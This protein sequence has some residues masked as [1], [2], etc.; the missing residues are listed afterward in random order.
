MLVAATGQ[1]LFVVAAT[2][3]CAVRLDSVGHA[4][5]LHYF[6][7]TGM[8]GIARIALLSYTEHERLFMSFVSSCHLRL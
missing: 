2:V 6:G 3:I 8:Q 7:Q 5:A 4:I 1:G